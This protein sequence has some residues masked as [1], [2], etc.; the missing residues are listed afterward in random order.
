MTRRQPVFLQA[1]CREIE[2]GISSR[3]WSGQDLPFPCLFT[4]RGGWKLLPSVMGATGCAW[5]DG[6]ATFIF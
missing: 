3:P 5:T 6:F 2:E 4:G 1:L